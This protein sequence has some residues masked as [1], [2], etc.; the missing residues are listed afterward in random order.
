[1]TLE[2]IALIALAGVIAGALN[3]AAGGGTLVSFP[4]LVWLGIPPITANISSSVGLLSGYLGGSLAYRRELSEQKR[5]V[6]TFTIVSIVGGV[7]G[8]ILLLSTSA[9]VFAGLVPF[10]VLG[11]AALLGLQPFLSRRLARR[12]EK[13]KLAGQPLGLQG[14]ISVWAQVGV[15]LAAIYGSYFG[16]GLGVMLLAVLALTVQEE[17]QKLN[18]LKSLLSL[19]INFIGVIVFVST[20][21]VDWGVVAVLAPAALVGGVFGGSL[22]RKLPPTVLRGLVVAF[23]TISGIVLFF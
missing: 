15:L 10:L 18:G 7:L 11:S 14:G 19:F 21:S 12:E 8:A 2:T 1:M 5:R 20:V 23:A 13:V 22:A 9:A 4:V 17:L 16:A 3:S 6:A